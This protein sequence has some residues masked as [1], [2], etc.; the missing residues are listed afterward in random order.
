MEIDVADFENVLSVPAQA[1]VS[2]D[3]KD[4]LA[5]RKPDGGFEWREVSQG[6]ANGDSVEIKK[7]VRAGEQ[8]ILEPAKLKDQAVRGRKSVKPT[9]PDG[10]KAGWP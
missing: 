5:I 8:V 2:F 4:H 10:Q 7:G 1:V 6:V 9:T 3:N